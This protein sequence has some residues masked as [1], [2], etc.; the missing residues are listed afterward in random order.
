MG[1]AYTQTEY[2]IST[3]DNR[4]FTFASGIFNYVYPG[5]K[6]LLSGDVAELEAP[7][8]VVGTPIRHVRAGGQAFAVVFGASF[9]Q[10]TL[11][12]SAYSD[13]MIYLF[14]HRKWY[15]VGLGFERGG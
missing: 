7:N 10:R 3:D 13:T 2:I 5:P 14:F 12:L 9:S 6:L 11:W 4:V 1:F 15:C 8:D